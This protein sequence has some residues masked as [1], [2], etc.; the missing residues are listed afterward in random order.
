MAFCGPSHWR[1][2]HDSPGRVQMP[3]LALQQIS[4]TLHVFRPHCTLTGSD[5]APQNVW[6]HVPPG[7]VQMPQLAL[8]HVVPAGQARSPQ[9]GEAAGQGPG[10]DAGVAGTAAGGDDRTSTRVRGP[11]RVAGTFGPGAAPT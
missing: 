7:G 5:G 4:P 6:S 11:S 8:Q 2:E 3:Q 10:A 9:R 1:C